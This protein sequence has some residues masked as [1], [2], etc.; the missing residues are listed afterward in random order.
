[1]EKIID[2]RNGEPL[3]SVDTYTKTGTKAA[4]E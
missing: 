1:M 4:N 3:L 2:H